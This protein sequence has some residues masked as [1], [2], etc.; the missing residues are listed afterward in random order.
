M[1]KRTRARELALQALY[2]IDLRKDLTEIEIDEFLEKESDDV[3]MLNFARELVQGCLAKLG[4]ID[5]AI[6][7]VAENWDIHRMAVL[8]RNIL[9]LAVYELKYLDDVPPK[10]TINEAVELGKR[11]STASSGAF[12]NGILDRIKRELS[13]ETDS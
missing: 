4:E 6:K 5:A 1:R 11:F 8:D 2:Q 12:I 9:R 7:E 3:G 13:D 10:V